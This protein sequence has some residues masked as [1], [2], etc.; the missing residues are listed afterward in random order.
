MGQQAGRRAKERGGEE[1]R[2]HHSP[3]EL[4]HVVPI[5]VRREGQV[6]VLTEQPSNRIVGG[7]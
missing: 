6:M 3:H 5:S 7:R 2:I 1:E 4:F